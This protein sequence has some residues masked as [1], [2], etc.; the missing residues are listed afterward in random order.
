MNFAE[1]PIS[2]NQTSKRPGPAYH[3]ELGADTLDSMIT[4]TGDVAGSIDIDRNRATPD[5]SDYYKSLRAKLQSNASF[6]YIIHT[7]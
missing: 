3:Q 1:T 2:I 6:K 7:I 5:S 4:L